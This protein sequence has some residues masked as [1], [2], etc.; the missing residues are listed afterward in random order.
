VLSSGTDISDFIK[1]NSNC[2][3][4]DLFVFNKPI[5]KNN[6]LKFRRPEVFTN[7]DNL[8]IFDRNE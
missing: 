2:K 7:K 5:P 4:I 3:E 1:E 8:L 6:S